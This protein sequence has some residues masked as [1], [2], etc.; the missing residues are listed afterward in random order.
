M[1]PN[2]AL[3]L[4]MIIVLF[5]GPILELIFRIPLGVMG[6]FMAGFIAAAY[7]I[8]KYRYDRK[9]RDRLEKATSDYLDM[10]ISEIEHSEEKPDDSP[11]L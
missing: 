6:M 2:R 9:Q 5:L 7:G 10:R 1:N 11:S 8:A 3:G 4:S